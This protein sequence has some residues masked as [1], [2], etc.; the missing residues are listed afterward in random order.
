MTVLL[1]PNG[2]PFFGGTYFPPTDSIGRPGFPR[3]LAAVATHGASSA[4]EIEQ[5]AASS[6]ADLIR[7]ITSAGA[8]GG[9]LDP[10]V[11]DARRSA[12]RAVRPAQRRLRRRAKVPPPMALEF[13]L[14]CHHRRDSRAARH[15]RRDAANAWP[16]AAFTTSS[17]A[18]FTATAPM[19]DWLIPHFEKMLYDN[20][21]LAAYTGAF[22]TT[23]KSSTG[24]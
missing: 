1:T 21:Q 20:A 18:A 19:S 4:R 14:R 8:S 7:A 15:G 12:R 16:T 24:A 10:P 17:A 11:L 23:G 13:L 2:K 9:T 6:T 3:V 5:R 22:Q